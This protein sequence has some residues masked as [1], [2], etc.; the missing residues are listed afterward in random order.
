VDCS[1]CVDRARVFAMRWT[2]VG[3]WVEKR[4]MVERCALKVAGAERDGT[5]GDVK[6]TAFGY[7]SM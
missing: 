2:E 7:W 4:E 1:R 5:A 3:E 6:A